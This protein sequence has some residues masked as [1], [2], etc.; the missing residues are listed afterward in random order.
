MMMA[1]TTVTIKKAKTRYGSSWLELPRLRN[2]SEVTRAMDV[3]QSKGWK[4]QHDSKPKRRKDDGDL[5]AEESSVSVV[6][7]RP[8]ALKRPANDDPELERERRRIV[9]DGLDVDVIR[10]SKGLFAGLLDLAAL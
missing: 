3:L 7:Q 9:L 1:G 5:L 6:G 4:R 8:E 10:F 2:V